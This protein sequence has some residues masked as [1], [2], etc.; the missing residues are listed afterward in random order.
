MQLAINAF[1]SYTLNAA[2]YK[3]GSSFS[4]EQRAILQ[5]LLSEAA[6]EKVNLTFDPTNPMK[7]TQAEAELQGKIGILQYLL[8]LENSLKG[9]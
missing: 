3:A 5:N 6:I 1:T 9:N 7:F 2:E 4:S 8:D